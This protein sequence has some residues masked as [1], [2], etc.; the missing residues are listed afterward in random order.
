MV[1][2]GFVFFIFGHNAT[3]TIW[4]GVEFNSDFVGKLGLAP[5]CGEPVEPAETRGVCA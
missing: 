3:S 5:T 2:V 1:I 4:A